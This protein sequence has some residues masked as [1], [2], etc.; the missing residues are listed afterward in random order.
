MTPLLRVH[1]E[2]R[3][4]APALVAPERIW[5]YR[6]LEAAV[7]GT[8]RRMVAE[9]LGAGDRV[10]LRPERDARTIILLW[11]LWRIGAVAVPLSLRL[12]PAV[13]RERA[14]RLNCH[15]FV[16]AEASGERDLRVCSPADLLRENPPA[17]R[18]PSVLPVDR[19]ATIVCTSGSTGRPKAA[20]HSWA[21]H[22]YSAKGS[23]ANLP[24]RPGDRWLLSLPLYHVGGLAILVRC[25]LAGAAVALPP[26]DSSP[27]TALSETDATHTSYV[28]TQ[29]QRLLAETSA[30]PPALRAVL[31]GG[32]PI[33]SA[34][35]DRAH[36]HRWP[37]LTSYGC[38]EMASQV[39]TT[40]PGAS[41]S[42]L[43]TAG[44]RLPHRRLRIDEDGQILVAGRT[45]FRGYVE[46][47]EL[48]DPRTA[49]GWYPTGDRGELDAQGR[50][51]VVGRMDR[52]FISGGENI[53]PEEIEAALE[54][55]SGVIRAVVV[56]VPNAT[57]GERPVA[58]LEGEE[59]D[60][61]VLRERLAE[62]LPAFK[63]PDAFYR[64]PGEGEREGLKVDRR[65]LA[66]W[67]ETNHEGSG[68][69]P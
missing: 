59:E 46:G 40:F 48:R 1:A 66:A 30:P 62:R 17:D 61:S 50:L 42:A 28:A 65:K 67:A 27:A 37:V 26:P 53:Q 32:G 63:I 29:F 69:T 41:R 20:L 34:L 47:E 10:A 13:Q 22:L 9:G 8:A 60:A 35:L 39:T 31:L 23:N 14:Q 6:D 2:G 33:P 36:A 38:T 3:P 55:L 4:D 64:F 18:V 54:Q 21:N 12:P 68:S 24:L 16:G 57:Y 58:F 49:T 19:D 44:R 11:A 52:M 5:T 56:P 51:R 15:L 45:L 43:N 7:S 25:A